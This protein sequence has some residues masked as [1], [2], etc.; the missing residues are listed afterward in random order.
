MIVKD[1]VKLR[2]IQ[3]RHIENLW[4]EQQ[5]KDVQTLIDMM[6]AAALAGAQST[7]NPMG[8]DMLKQAKKDF[9]EA[10][11]E[12]NERYRCLGPSTL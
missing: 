9:I 5:Q 7:F 3:N 6:E 11:M 10:V 2:D 1:L 12:M 8:M 4:C